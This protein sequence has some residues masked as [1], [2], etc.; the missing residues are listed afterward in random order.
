VRQEDDL[1]QALQGTLALDRP[2]RRLS[3]LLEFLDPTD[4]EGM[5]ARLKRWS[6]S[7]G[8]PYAWVFDNAND[9]IVP[10]LDTNT[11]V[12]F[13]VTDFLDHPT[14]R[15]PLSMY[16]FHLVRRLVDG[17]RLVVW[18]D[19]FARVLADRSF[20]D[21][22]RTG[23]EGWRKK[24]AA[25]GAFTQSAGQVLSSSIARAIVEQTPTKLFF[26]NPDADHAEY[27]EGFNLSEREFHL[28]KH[29]LQRGRAPRPSR[30]G[31]RARRDLGTHRQR[32]THEAPHA[33]RPSP[34][35][36]AL[37]RHHSPQ[38]DPPCLR[39][40]PPPCSSSASPPRSTL[41]ASRS[42]MS[43]PSASSSSRSPTGSNSSPP[44]ASSSTSC[45]APTTP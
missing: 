19:E 11:I 17:R 20:S 36:A 31:L 41:A 33:A 30:D 42:S 37:A 22:A 34:L 10:V 25:L 6:A 7:E 4:P 28:V 35:A 32:R 16:L 12:G 39:D 2:A 40:S 23:L 18:A 9:D 3:R 44:W 21:F 15:D 26:P 27:T 1:D 13:D 14:V 8:G 43:R 24:N 29:A 45:T 5:H 38:G